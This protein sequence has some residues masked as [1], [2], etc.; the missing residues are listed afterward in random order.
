VEKSIRRKL[1]II[2]I[3]STHDRWYK[4]EELANQLSC[5]EKTIRNDINL[6]N[7][8]LPKGWAI[9]IIKGKG[10]YINKPIS[11]SIN[12]IRSLYI[13]NSLSFQ[14]IKLIIFNNVM[15]INNLANALYIQ[16]QAVYKILNEVV[17]LLES[18]NLQLK[19]G[20]L[21]IIGREFEIRLLCCDILNTLNC[22]STHNITH[23]PFDD[24]SFSTMKE[25]VSTTTTNYKLFIYP[26]T[27][28]KYVYFLGTMFHR[29]SK[30]I[31]LG[32]TEQTKNRIKESVFYKISDEIC[33]KVENKYNVSISYD[34]RIAFTLS[35]STL[36][37]Y[38]Y[39]ELEKTEF[40]KLF[41]SRKTPYYQ[42][43]YEVVERLENNLGIPL[44]EDDDFLYTFQ[45]QYKRY[46][47][48]LYSI[49]KS[50]PSY[51]I[52][53]YANKHYAELYDQVKNILLD[54]TTEKSYPNIT[55]DGIAKVTLNVQSAKNRIANLNKKVLLLT[56]N[57]PAVHS[58]ISSKLKNEFGQNIQI[59]H[60]NQD[61]IMLEG[62]NKLQIDLIIADFQFE[63]KTTHPTVIID[64]TL[65]QRDIYQISLLFNQN[66]K[67][68][69]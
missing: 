52:D 58:Y 6:I 3:L 44:F 9:E 63:L 32:L 39:Y 31:D 66:K 45:M 21:Q 56:S 26:M 28:N 48:I 69:I 53:R 43:M 23:W 8:N 11:A 51:P 15:T 57:G 60:P 40:L 68:H 33:N 50:E 20:P 65:T 41:H 24:I 55:K 18:Y 25:F 61:D 1:Q 30:D 54:W 16:Q 10:I 49:D 64:P 42:D 37:F 35:I 27:L 59:L 14:A 2:D 22:P 67:R 62:L 19:R 34:E 17:I 13:K 29:I 5:N 36:P 38:S 47:L 46:S 7:S 4:S 12:Q